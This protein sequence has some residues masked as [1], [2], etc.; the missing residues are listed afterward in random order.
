[1]LLKRRIERG[2]DTM[3]ERNREYLEK[4]GEYTGPEDVSILTEKSEEE[5]SIGQAGLRDYISGSASAAPSKSKEWEL[6]DEMEREKEVIQAYRKKNEELDFEKGDITAIIIAAF[7]TFGP[8]ILGILGVGALMVY[9][10][11]R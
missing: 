4:Q 7:I 3:R 6:M 1:M 9:L 11:G 10:L 8:V 5:Q 2:M